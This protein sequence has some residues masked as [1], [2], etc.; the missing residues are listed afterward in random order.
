MYLRQVSWSASL[1]VKIEAILCSNI[2]QYAVR[3]GGFI[4]A[5]ADLLFPNPY[6][7]DTTKQLVT[8]FADRMQSKKLVLCKSGTMLLFLHKGVLV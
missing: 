8:A 4:C 1:Q 6:D 3:I 7:Q 2:S 5:S